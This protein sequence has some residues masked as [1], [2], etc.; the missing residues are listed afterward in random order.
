[1]INAVR[2]LLKNVNGSSSN[3]ALSPLAEPIDPMFRA[4][5][6]PSWLQSGHRSLFGTQPDSLYLD[7]RVR[8][9]LVLIASSPL[10]PLLRAKDDR[11]TEDP[12]TNRDMPPF[13]PTVLKT[14]DSGSHML[15]YSSDP[16]ADDIRGR[17]W[18]QYTLSVSGG[19]ATLT[20]DNGDSQVT[21]AV[22]GVFRVTAPNGMRLTI[23]PT[24][25]T[26]SWS[27]LGY[28][29]PRGLQPALRDFDSQVG[30]RFDEMIPPQTTDAHLLQIREIWDRRPI[31]EYPVRIAALLLATA[32]YIDTLPEKAAS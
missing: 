1:M 16:Q 6:L 19:D 28:A 20:A 32:W 24:S 23:T 29:R 11:M 2:A 3:Q 17:S 22:N 13:T 25:G 5:R 31:A 10:A 27:I 7:Y 9:L 4:R 21:A 26:A 14:A 12:L 30:P 18:Y 15:N 8:E